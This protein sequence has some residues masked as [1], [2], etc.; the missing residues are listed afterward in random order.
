MILV[1]VSF[2]LINS[3]CALL[4]P[5]LPT[6]QNYSEPSSIRF[7][8]YFHGFSGVYGFIINF[9]RFPVSFAEIYGFF[10][11][12]SYAWNN[13]PYTS[14]KLCTMRDHADK[15][16]LSHGHFIQNTSK[17]LKFE[18]LCTEMCKLSLKAM[19]LLDMET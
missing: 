11:L 4:F 12:C 17:I 3:A 10:F 13:K 7:C 9:M 18:A 19:I 1:L 16:K 14:Q 8:P 6:S 2:T 15:S 5:Y